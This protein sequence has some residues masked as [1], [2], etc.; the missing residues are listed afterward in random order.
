MRIGILGTGAV[1][2]TF[3]TRLH[4]LDH[5]V[6]LGARETGNPRALEW[7]EAHAARCGT[8]AE[9][10]ADA[11]LVINATAG[12]HAVNALEMA[13]GNSALAG[14]VVLDVS[15]PL[16]FSTG[17]LRLSVCNTDS[18]GEQLQRSFPDARIVKSLNTV[19]GSVMV[20]P[21]LVPGQHTIFVAGNDADAKRAVTVLLGEFGWA[22]A[23]VL[24]LGGIE[25][26]RGMEMYMPLW[27]SILRALDGNLAFNIN[28][29]QG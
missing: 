20:E 12:Q 11:D 28:V 6:T 14:K 13:G 24:D 27:V 7:A 21:T 26:S 23:N 16:D 4:N 2:Q 3:G 29:I 22:A 5:D 19:N 15:N 10:V 1:G 18:V 17:E 25:A 8:F 9:A